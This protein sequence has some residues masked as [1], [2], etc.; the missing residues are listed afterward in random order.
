MAPGHKKVILME[1]LTYTV[2]KREFKETVTSG[3]D[4]ITIIPFKT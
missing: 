1:A 2:I 4:Q 3:K